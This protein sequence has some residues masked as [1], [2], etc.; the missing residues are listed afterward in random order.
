MVQTGL[1]RF[2][3]RRALFAAVLVLAVSS[4]ALLLAALA[5]P[6]RPLDADPQAVLA[7]RARLGL[8]R[9]LHEQYLAWIVRA[10]RLDFGESI[11]FGRPVGA[12]IRER[13]GN[14][15][16][17]GAAALILATLIGIPTGVFTGS[18]A[19]GALASAA[20]AASALL[21]AVPPLITSLL[22]LLLAA[23][24]GW[25]PAGGLP[26]TAGLGPVAALG[27][28]VRHLILPTLALALPVAASLERLQSAAL[29][30]ALDDPSV[31]AARARG[32]PPNRLLWRHAWRLSLKPVLAIY[33]IVVGSVLSGSFAVEIVTAWPGLGELTFQALRS[34]DLY[35]VAGCAAAGAGCLAAGILASDLALAAVDPRLEDAA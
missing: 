14:T 3:V 35:L 16:L 7:E 9:P 23:R 33:G 26:D 1:A 27:V 21:L 34:R 6:E 30:E 31:A 22:L 20:R 2:I 10:V 25:L 15:L 11:R 13:A 29:R 28:T 8:D 17:L 18:R 24:T 32:I 12:L 4:A 5:P 19:G